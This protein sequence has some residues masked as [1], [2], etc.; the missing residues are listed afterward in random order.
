MT[1]TVPSGAIAA[2]APAMLLNSV[3]T[4]VVAFCAVAAAGAGV[5]AGGGLGGGGG[6]GRSL[7]TGVGTSFPPACEPTNIVLP[8]GEK[9]THHTLDFAASGPSCSPFAFTSQSLMA[10]SR[11]P[12]ASRVPSGA[13][14]TLVT[15]S[16][17]PGSVANSLESEVVQS[18]IVRSAPA[19][20]SFDPSGE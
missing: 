4:S 17:W 16:L 14:L 9:V 8:S 2:V 6:G 13:K 12:L 18:L 11:L 20:A 10:P 5:G 3:G 1:V 7:A 19:V 15:Q